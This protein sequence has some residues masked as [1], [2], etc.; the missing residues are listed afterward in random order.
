MSLVD[1]AGSRAGK[2]TV[3][4]R[5]A[6]GV[7]IGDHNTQDNIFYAGPHRLR[8]DGMA[9]SA[10]SGSRGTWMEVPGGQGVQVGDHNTQDNTFIGQY[11]GT[12]ILPAQPGSVVGRCASAMYPR[13]PPHSSRGTLCWRRWAAVGRQGRLCMRSP[14][15]GGLARRRWPR[16][17]PARGWLMAGAWWP[18]LVPG[19]WLRC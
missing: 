13:C 4:A 11:V 18:G 8:R 17:M 15:C 3:D 5:G 19:T 16:L 1:A 10:G 2:Y 7:Q 9:G 14:G 6:Q 12:Q